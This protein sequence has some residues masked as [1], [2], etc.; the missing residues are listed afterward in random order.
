[1][2]V[3]VTV[4]GITLDIKMDVKELIELGEYLDNTED[5]TTTV[6]EDSYGY[7][8]EQFD[9]TTMTDYSVS[10]V[11]KGYKIYT[12][13]GVLNTRYYRWCKNSIFDDRSRLN[14]DL[15]NVKLSIDDHIKRDLYEI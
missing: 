4:R 5:T 13:H 7:G 12:T 11:Y 8:V 3:T 1:M 9:M 14:E 15:A 2:Q 10:E 6:A